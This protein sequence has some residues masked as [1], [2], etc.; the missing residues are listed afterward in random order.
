MATGIQSSNSRRVVTVRLVESATAANAVPAGLPS[1]TPATGVGFD[2]GLLGYGNIFPLDCTVRVY[3]TAGSN[4]M[5][6]SYGRLYGYSIV[7][8]LWSPLGAGASTT[9]G[10]L[11][12]GLAF[13]EDETDLI[14]TQERFD[15][16]G[17]FDGIYCRLGVFGGTATALSV[18][19]DFPR[20]ARR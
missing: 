10:M 7:S 15:L 1:G 2:M 6:C 8:G 3:S 9:S 5:S 4:T 12:N 14:R 19:I 17:H 16:P 18:E 11:N 20:Y 13:A